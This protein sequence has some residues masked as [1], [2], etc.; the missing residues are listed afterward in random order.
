MSGLGG[1]AEGVAVAEPT[2]QEPG[3]PAVVASSRGRTRQ[4]A[5]LGVAILASVLV[6]ALCIAAFGA[7]PIV[8]FESLMTGAFGTPF[9]FGET[10]M[11]T[12]ILALTALATAI[13]FTAGVWNVGGEGQLY[14]GAIAA[15]AVAFVMPAATPHWAHAS[16]ALVA[17]LAGGSFWA[18]IAGFLKLWFNANEVIVTLMLVFVAMFLAEY[19]ISS[20]WPDLSHTTRLIPDSATLPVIWTGTRVNVGVFLVGLCLVGSW[21]ALSRTALGFKTRAV[22]LNPAASRLNGVNIGRIQLLAMGVGGAFA[23][24]AGGIAVLGLNGALISGFSDNWGF[25]GIAV[26]L[27]AR[28][29]PKW[30]LPSA[31]LFASLKAGSSKMQ[32]ETG[33]SPAAGL[34]VIAVIV[35]V[36]LAFQ[37]IRVDTGKATA[38]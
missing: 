21:F 26:A 35:L 28:L 3:R 25:I 31:I 16:L 15:T 22:G 11:L 20:L 2:R 14:A 24:A 7:N 34:M 9:G 33:L 4:A 17:A 27:L 5:R 18:L 38:D 10:I 23:G 30:I 36:L 12:S 37:V 19:V 8:A 32:V 13:P 6:V 29:S 1:P